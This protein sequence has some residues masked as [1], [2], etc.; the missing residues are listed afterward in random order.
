M[1]FQKCYTE[2]GAETFLLL[3]HSRIKVSQQ[4]S[5]PLL[6]EGSFIGSNIVLLERLTEQLIK[7]H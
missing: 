2:S 1:T 7:L 3:F 5:F 4:T 6:C